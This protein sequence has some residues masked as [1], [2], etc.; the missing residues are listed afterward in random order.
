MRIIK[1]FALLTLAATGAV[2]S[3]WNGYQSTCP[4]NPMTSSTCQTSTTINTYCQTSTTTPYTCMCQ[5]T[6]R[7]KK[8]YPQCSRK[9]YCCHNGDSCDGWPDGMAQEDCC[10]N[11]QPKCCDDEGDFMSWGQYGQADCEDC[12]MYEGD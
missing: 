3:P 6:P 7:P 4:C 10:P 2:A 12:Q 8:H 11:G 1:T 5:P 9:A